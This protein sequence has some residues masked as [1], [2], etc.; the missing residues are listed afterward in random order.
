MRAEAVD[1]VRAGPLEPAQGF[2]QYDPSERV[3]ARL[4]LARGGIFNGQEAG[5]DI[6]G[7]GSLVPYAGAMRK[8]RLEGRSP[9][10]AFEAVEEA[11][12]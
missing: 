11:L 10:R 4:A 12:R 1:V 5:I 8:R 3:A 6:M 2:R 7:D 9:D